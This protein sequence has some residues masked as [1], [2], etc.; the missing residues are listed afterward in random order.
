[1]ATWG[2]GGEDV[3]GCDGGGTLEPDQVGRLD[4]NL[5]LIGR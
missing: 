5:R 2:S 4:F 3:R 1:M